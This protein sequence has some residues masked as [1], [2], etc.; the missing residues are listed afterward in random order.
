MQ[1]E[2]SSSL[3]PASGRATYTPGYAGL[4]MLMIIYG[5]GLFLMG[6][7]LIAEPLR[8]VFL[9]TKATSEATTVVVAK[10]GLPDV[11]LKDEQQVEA[12]L[13]PND[14]SY[15][16]WNEFAYQAEDGHSVAIRCP[17]GS[18][19]KP[20]YPLVDAD[21]LPTVCLIYYD[22][23]H[24]QEIVFPLIV[25]TW[26]APGVLIIVGLLGAAIGGFLCY[27]ARRPI[28]LPHFAQG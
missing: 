19:L 9:G 3:T 10:Q 2:P 25:S 6:L 20:L 15:I 13:K 12:S 11:V 8:L 1:T 26:F 14:Y 7:A 21:G 4:K 28:E 17:V 27:W 5:L 16:F 18:R 24:P 23:H 22:P